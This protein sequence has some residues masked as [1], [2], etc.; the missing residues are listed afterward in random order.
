MQRSLQPFFLSFGMINFQS[1]GATFRIQNFLRSNLL[2]KTLFLKIQG[3]YWVW[4][5]FSIFI[6]SIASSWTKDSLAKST[7]PKISKMNIWSLTCTQYMNF[8]FEMQRVISQTPVTQ[9]L[10]AWAAFSSKTKCWN[11]QMRHLISSKFLTFTS[12]IIDKSWDIFLII[13]KIS[14]DFKLNSSFL[15]RLEIF[16]RSLEVNWSRSHC[17]H[18]R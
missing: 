12:I 17:F 13:K 4:E 9:V 2:F 7:Q 10:A 15:A 8:G 18:Q 11:A 5:C 14:K 3:K 6:V 16:G 1:N